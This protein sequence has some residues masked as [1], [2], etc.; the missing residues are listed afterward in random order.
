MK[1]HSSYLFGRWVQ[2]AISLATTDT[3][4][5]LFKF[6]A[7]N[8]LTLWGPVGEIS[9]YAGKQWADLISQ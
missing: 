8:Q 2:N 7:I 6:N 5:K 4:R 3:D 9:D 1:S